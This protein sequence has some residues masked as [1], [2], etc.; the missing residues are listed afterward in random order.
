MKNE[1]KWNPQTDDNGWIVPADQDEVD[2]F[3]AGLTERITSIDE[4]IMEL[5]QAIDDLRL[6]Q[7]RC[8]DRKQDLEEWTW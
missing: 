4:K 2:R 7:R 5:Q 8:A 6:E 3:I 1:R